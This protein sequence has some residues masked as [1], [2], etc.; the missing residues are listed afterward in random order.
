MKQF[1]SDLKEGDKVGSVFLVRER[2]LM[3]FR[4]KPGRYLHLVVADRSGEMEGRVWENAENLLQVC[5]QGR[6]VYVTGEVFSFR[7][8]LQLRVTA[9]RAPR[10]G[11]FDP[12]DFVA[13]SSR[14]VEEMRREL[15]EMV[16]NMRPGP[17]QRVALAFLDSEWY[18]RFCRAPAAQYHHHNYTGGLLE[19]TL[20][21]ARVALR[22]AEL[23]EGIDRELL[24]L[25]ALVH[26]LGKVREMDFTPGIEYTDEGKLLGHIIM[27]IEM[28][29]ELMDRVGGVEPYLRTQVLHMIASHHG[30]YEWQSPKRPQFLEAKLLHLADL[31]DAEVYKFKDAAPRGEGEKWSYSH[32]RV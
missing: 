30:E 15:V 9:L 24:L 21:V 3:D 5:H 27:G 32:R 18:P 16:Q 13:M 17:L 2:R 25:G 4:N 20:G 14:P 6:V 1:I 11:E 29:G 22:V 23:Y 8:S 12:A 26:D 28:A 19:H 10:E 7:D 31:T